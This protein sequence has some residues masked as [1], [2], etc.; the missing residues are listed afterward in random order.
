MRFQ[1]KVVI[2]TGGAKGIGAACIERFAD[3]GARVI[4]A[5][6]D[7]KAGLELETQL[8]QTGKK[9]LFAHCD[10]SKKQDVDETV[11]KA[12]EKFGQ[13]DVL[14]SNAGIAHSEDFLTLKEE[15][16]DR[17]LDINLKGMFLINQRVAQHMVENKIEG[18]IINMASINSVVAIPAQTPY[19]V[20][21][22]GVAQL[23]KV[24]ALS[25]AQYNIRVNAVGPGSI[26]TEMLSSVNSNPEAKQRILSRTPMGRIGDPSE[27]ASVTAFLASDDASYMTGQTLFPEGGRLALNYT[28]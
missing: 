24:M 9:A 6:I 23:T 13:I 1:D 26:M 8:N 7:D 12:I 18:A 22:G 28:V 15:D 21:K 2:V 14:V 25:L 10:V 17:V 3:E 4:I 5:D 27:I 20:S 16:F 19:T 11:A